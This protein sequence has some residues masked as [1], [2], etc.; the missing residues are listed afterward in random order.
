M[1]S[2]EGLASPESQRLELRRKTAIVRGWQGGQQAIL[3][4]RRW[5][6]LSQGPSLE[7]AVRGIATRKILLRPIFQICTLAYRRSGPDSLSCA[8]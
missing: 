1:D 6:R 5:F 4:L 8:R 3:V 2:V 7:P